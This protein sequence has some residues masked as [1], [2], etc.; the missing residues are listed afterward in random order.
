MAMILC[1][2]RDDK[3][4]VYSNDERYPQQT[5]EMSEDSSDIVQDREGEWLILTLTL[6]L[7]LILTLTLT[8]TQIQIFEGKL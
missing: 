6:I 8:L 3:E 5:R 1:E 7:I 2:R 4:N